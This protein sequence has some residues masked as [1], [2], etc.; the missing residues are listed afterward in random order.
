MGNGYGY[1]CKKCKK[2]KN[3]LYGVGFLGY[4][5][6]YTENKFNELIEMGKEEKLKNI[7]NLEDFLK[8]ENVS[9]KDGYGYDAYI[10]PKCNFIDNKF[11]YILYSN[12]KI[13][14]PKYSCKYCE[15]DLRIKKSKEDFKLK[16]DFCGSTD[17]EK[18]SYLINWD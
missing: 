2:E 3:I 4:K 15:N 11:R 12:N 7:V 9:L 8:L 16:C 1:I 10:C 13:F 14:I 18:E 5:E 17:F 6:Y